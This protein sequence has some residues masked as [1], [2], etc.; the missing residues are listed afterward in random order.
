MPIDRRTLL[1]SSVATAAA[2]TASTVATTKAAAK[3]SK[4]PEASAPKNRI[5]TLEEHYMSTSM[6][7][8]IPQL[9]E[10]ASYMSPDLKKHLTD[11]D[12]G[13]LQ[14]MDESGITVQVL[15]HTNVGADLL[16]GAEGIQFA[17]KSNDHLAERVK[18]YPNRFAGFAHLPMRSPEAAADELERAIK[19]LGFRGALISGMTQDLFLDDPRFAPILAR[20]EALDVPIY[21]H[22]NIPPKAVY[23][24]YYGRLPEID[25][26]LLAWGGYGWHAETAVHIF[27]LAVSGTL[28]K[29]PR[30][31]I[32]IGHMGETLPFMLDRMDHAAVDLGGYSKGF[33]EVILDHVYITTSG[34]FSTSAFLCAL[35]KFGADRIL[36]SVDYPYSKASLARRWVDTIPVSPV[37]KLKIMHGNADRVL[38]LD[39]TI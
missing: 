30:L 29:Y 37:D 3:D 36:F 11:L 39:S 13:R 4:S 31:K 8:K 35:T 33:S 28:D 7:E 12:T 32:I 24:I 6:V 19:Q 38:K 21:L 16:D 27:R 10:R 17:Q 34:V 18:Q 9:R 26:H 20:A 22:P 25:R 1:T 23:D 2:I 5:V 15:S 14:D